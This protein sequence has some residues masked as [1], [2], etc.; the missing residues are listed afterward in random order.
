MEAGR[1]SVDLKMAFCYGSLELCK[2]TLNTDL[3]I[4][5]SLNE[6]KGN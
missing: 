2:I 6:M 3:L 5:K 4:N 1:E